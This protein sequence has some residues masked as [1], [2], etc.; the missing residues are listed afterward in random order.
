MTSTDALAQ[1]VFAGFGVAVLVFLRVGAAMAVL[2][3][4]GEQSLSV[5]IRL[6]AALA[7]T[8]IVFP[9]VAGRFDWPGLSPAVLVL[10]L[11]TETVAGLFLGLSL[12]L[13][14]LAIQTAGA[15]AAQSTSLSQIMGTAGADPLP[16]IGH[17]LT[18]SALA[19][20][21][22]VGF[23]VK[24]AGFLILTYEILPPLRF[25][26]A[27]ALSAAGADRVARSFALAFSLAAPFVLLSVLY[28]LTLGA[29]NKAMPQLMVAFVGAPLITFG[30]I[31][32]LFLAAPVILQAW[33]TA[34]NAFLANPFGN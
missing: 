33:H 9:A 20:L 15:I 31:A 5:R 34:F 1:E 11:A 19:L 32:L 30:S 14:I 24:A 18:V 21:L 12:R 28:N 3:A 13:F 27:A 2:P 4:L 17:I 23:H 22:S 8:A 26:D 29:I 16:A 10:A 6:V 25:P 7:L